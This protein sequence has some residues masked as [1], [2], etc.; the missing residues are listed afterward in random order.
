MSAPAKKKVLIT[1]AKSDSEKFAEL[2][3][4][5][6]ALPIICPLIERKLRPPSLDLQTNSNDWL[7]FTSVTGV[8][9]FLIQY[10]SFFLANS[11]KVAVIGD[12][13]KQ[14][15]ERH[16]IRVD[17][18]PKV[19]RAKNMMAEFFQKF[20]QVNRIIH[21]KGNL[22]LSTIQEACKE[23][24]I[25]YQGIIVYETNLLTPNDQ[26]KDDINRAD[27]LTATSPSTI[28]ALVQAIKLMPTKAQIIQR[29]IICI[30]PTTAKAAKR[31]AFKQILTAE[32]YTVEGMIEKISILINQTKE[33][34]K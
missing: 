12:A 9:S 14:A 30:G 31:N 17:F 7:I 26:E 5:E 21:I 32:T 29:P 13:T 4:Q 2:I 15:L 16:G 28:E 18:M 22:A 23:K 6:G 8:E 25:S 10:K 34:V 3:R 11:C 1:R 20:H 24:G 19:Y 33:T 27:F